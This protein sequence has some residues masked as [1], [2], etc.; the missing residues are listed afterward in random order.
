MA[1][2]EHDDGVSPKTILEELK[3]L[4]A[5]EP[6]LNVAWEERLGKSR[7]ILWE[8]CSWKFFRS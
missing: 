6:L 4:E 7:F 3:I 8:R 5:E 2:V 1:K